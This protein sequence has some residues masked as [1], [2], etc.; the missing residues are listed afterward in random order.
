M[1]NEDA[2]QSSKGVPFTQLDQ[3]NSDFAMAVALQEQE[4]AFS[5]LESIESEDSEEYNSES[6]YEEGNVNDY[7]Y[8]E[9]LEAG[10][11]LEF[12]EGQGSNDDEDMEDDDFEDDDDD[13]DD[14]GIDPDDLS[15]EELIALGEIIGVEK[16][17]LSPNEISSCLV[18]CNFRSDECKTGIDRCVICQVEYE[19]GEGVVALP[20]CEHPYHSECITKWLQVKK[21]CPICSTEISSPKN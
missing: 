7:E 11:D 4:R 16:R 1:E 19:E 13:D 10:G 9:G 15:Y 18:R 3:V 20:N 8:F 12:L 14:D 17:G 5:M 21:I 6:S 2:K